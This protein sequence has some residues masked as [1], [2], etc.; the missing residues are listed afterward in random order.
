MWD[1]ALA[2]CCGGAGDEQE[3]AASQQIK[4]RTPALE[5]KS[6]LVEATLREHSALRVTPSK[7]VWNRSRS[8]DRMVA[9]I[10]APF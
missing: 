3:Y 7:E 4:A 10:I 1:L 6:E 8:N 2:A 9:S 5:R